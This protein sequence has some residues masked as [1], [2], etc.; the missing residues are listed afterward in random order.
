MHLRKKD[1]N[2]MKNQILMWT[3]MKRNRDVRKKSHK[4]LDEFFSYHMSYEKIEIFR[5]H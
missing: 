3:L 1:A 4:E 5:I 2:L